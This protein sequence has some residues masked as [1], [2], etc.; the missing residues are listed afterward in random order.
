MFAVL[1]LFL[2]GTGLVTPATRRTS[3]RSGART[4]R[5]GGSSTMTQSYEERLK[6]LSDRVEQLDGSRHSRPPR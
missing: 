6:A 3:T 4:T 2:S 1:L 5:S